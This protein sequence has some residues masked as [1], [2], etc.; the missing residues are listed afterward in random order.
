MIIF[1][2]ALLWLV[3]NYANGVK[4]S[5]TFEEVTVSMVMEKY[6]HSLPMTS[7]RVAPNSLI[8]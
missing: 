6:V 8:L 5:Q 1:T 3:L 7:P 2:I 4:S